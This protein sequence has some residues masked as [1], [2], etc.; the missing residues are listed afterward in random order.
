VAE[1]QA[2]VEIGVAGL[3]VGQLD[4]AANRQGPGV[5]GTAVGGLLGIGRQSSRFDVGQSRLALEID[6]EHGPRDPSRTSAT[7]TS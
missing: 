2:D 7:T 5:A 4:A 6:L 1:A 3:L